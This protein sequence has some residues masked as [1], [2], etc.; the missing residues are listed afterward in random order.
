[1]TAQGLLRSDVKIMSVP[2]FHDYFP[3]F[4]D[5]FM[6]YV[7]LNLFIQIKVIKSI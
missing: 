7:L 5:T 4:L 3:G 2:D 6:S 1:M